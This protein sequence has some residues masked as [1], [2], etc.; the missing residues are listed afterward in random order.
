MARKKKVAVEPVTPPQDEALVL[1]E[2][3]IVAKYPDHIFEPGTL[4][5][6]G[7]YPA[8]FGQKRTIEIRCINCGKLRR[9]ATSDIFHVSQC[10]ECKANSVRQT[11]KDRRQAAK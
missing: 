1:A 5:P 2:A 11:A 10:R 6:S 8:E 7:A 3:E 4:A 9:I